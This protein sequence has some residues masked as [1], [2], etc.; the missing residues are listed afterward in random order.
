M[1][2]WCET[3]NLANQPPPLLKDALRSTSSLFP[4]AFCKSDS[5]FSQRRRMSFVVAELC[6]VLRPPSWIRPGYPNG[7]TRLLVLC[8]RLHEKHQFEKWE[9]YHNHFILRMV[10]KIEFLI[11]HIH[12]TLWK[13][14]QTLAFAPSTR[15][16][17]AGYFWILNYKFFCCGFKNA[18]SRPHV[19][20]EL[21]ASFTFTNKIILFLHQINKKLNQT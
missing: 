20:F 10:C 14:N 8:V 18:S 19:Q 15:T 5:F 21:F 9:C 11:F 7:V 6:C 2:W 4:H 16:Y 3:V 1:C 17:S 12:T 13:K